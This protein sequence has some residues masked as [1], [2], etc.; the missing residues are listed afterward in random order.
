MQQVTKGMARSACSI[1]GQRL[2]LVCFGWLGVAIHELAHALFC[3]IFLHKIIEIKLFSPDLETGQLGYVRHS[4]DQTSFYQSCGNF[5]IGL[6]PIVV[7]S[8]IIYLSALWL[9]EPSFKSGLIHSDVGL[10]ELM[11]SSFCLAWDY[12]VGL[13]HF[14]ALSRWQTYLF[15]YISLSVGSNITL[16]VAD[17]SGALRGFVSF[18]VI[19]FLMNLSTLFLGDFTSRIYTQL[20]P[21]FQWFYSIML[22]VILVCLGFNL[23]F[24][25]FGS[26]GSH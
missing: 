9:L 15:L 24:L 12:F 25:G 13:F 8:L 17:L 11:S 14:S 19:L 20:I 3:L 5:F 21:F 1:M 10:V 4:Y 16:S 22:F 23:L 7:G 18:V 2:Y 26:K 6:G